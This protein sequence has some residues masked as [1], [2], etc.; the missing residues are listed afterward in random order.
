MARLN[1][2]PIPRFAFLALGLHALVGAALWWSFYGA[3]HGPSSSG[4]SLTWISP[5]DFQ[6]AKPL[7]P[8]SVHV[9]RQ[10]VDTKPMLAVVGVP[11]PVE[12][13]PKAVAI[14]PA[15]ALELIQ[16]QQAGSPAA[17]VRPKPEPTPAPPPVAPMPAPDSKR[18]D[19]PVPPTDVSR[20]ITVSRCDAAPGGKPASLLDVAAL[21]SGA[22]IAGEDKG[23]RFDEV[24]RAII[25]GFLGTWSPPKAST[26]AIDQRTAHLNVT[27]DRTGRLLSFKFAKRS[28]NEDFDSSVIDA[29]DALDKIEVQLPASYSEDHYKFQVHFHVE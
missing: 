8:S 12:P 21:D 11:A 23:V 2:Q 9:A 25:D 26:L 1:L 5:A 13:V 18:A 16:S 20:F 17:G 27:I 14:D 3:P 10:D 15:K 19:K 22:A 24:D 28:G 6:P 4:R 29:A 7:P